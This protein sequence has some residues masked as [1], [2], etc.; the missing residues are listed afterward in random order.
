MVS[1]CGEIK[2]VVQVFLLEKNM[3]D[4]LNSLPSITVRTD[5]VPFKC[6]VCGGFGTVSNARITCHGCHGKGFLVIDQDRKREIYDYI[7]NKVKP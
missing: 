1:D 4:G 3:T 2:S 7:D 5:R 6:P